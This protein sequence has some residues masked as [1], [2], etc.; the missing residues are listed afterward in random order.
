MENSFNV[1]EAVEYMKDKAIVTTGNGDYFSLVNENI[2]YKF[3]GSS[4]SLSIN[5]FKKLF[6]ESNFTLVEDHSL[7]ID[8]LKDKEYYEKY[9]K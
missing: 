8:E 4:I 2:H 3:N 6:R 7:I 1:N 9:K 5:D